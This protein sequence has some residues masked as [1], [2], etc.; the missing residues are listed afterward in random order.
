MKVLVFLILVLLFCGCTTQP[1]EIAQTDGNN[2]VLNNISYPASDI[3]DGFV[4]DEDEI[5]L[6]DM[7]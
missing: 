1:A 4:L 5:D 6:G 3:E 2:Q 7:I